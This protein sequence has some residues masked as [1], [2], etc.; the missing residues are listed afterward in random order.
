MGWSI[1]LIIPHIM[2]KAIFTTLTFCACLFC[3]TACSTTEKQEKVLRHVVLFGF[4]PEVSNEQIQTVEEAFSKLPSQIDFIQDYEWGT[5]CSPEGL[6]QGLTHCFFLTF[7][8]E[9]D[10]DA[11]LIHPAHKEF[12][13]VLGNKASAVTVIDYWTK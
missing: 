9:A 12:G 10:R 13:K 8:S 3:F 2:K 1:Y 6:Q 4:K 7:N 11:Y 5:D